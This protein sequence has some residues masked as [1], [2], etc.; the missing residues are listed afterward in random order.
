MANRVLLDTS[1]LKISAPGVDVL[2]ALPSALIYSS[3][4]AGI[5]LLLKGMSYTN[6]TTVTVPFGKT[7]ERPP[8]I[9]LYWNGEG[10]QWSNLDLAGYGPNDSGWGWGSWLQPTYLQLSSPSGSPIN[11]AYVVW[12]Q[13][14]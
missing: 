7:F 3:D 2:S 9:N 6:G 4:W 5:G 8:L 1:G 13:V 12:D 14:S 11:W 10:N